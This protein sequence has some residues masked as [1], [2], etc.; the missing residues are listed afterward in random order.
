MGVVKHMV[1]DELERLCT[2][3]GGISIATE[4]HADD[5]PAQKKLIEI[6]NSF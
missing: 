5:C 3:D 2:C 6:F 4:D 1:E